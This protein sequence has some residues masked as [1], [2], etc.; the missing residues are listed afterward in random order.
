MPIDKKRDLAEHYEKQFERIVERLNPAQRQ[1]VDTIEGPVL[2]LAGPGTGKTH[3][4]SARIGRI[5]IDTDTAPYNILCLTFT[6]AGV[7]AMRKRLL[8]FI[9][10]EAHRIHIFTFHSF[11]NKI[12]QENLDYFGLQD[13]MPLSDIERV[14]ILQEML[15]TLPYSNPL[16]KGKS[17]PYYYIPHLEHLFRQIKMEGW[18]P[19]EIEKKIR[20]YLESLPARKEYQYQQ[21]RGGFRKGELKKGAFR[22]EQQRMERLSAAAALF[23]EYVRLLGKR[24]RYDYEDMILWVLQAFDRHSFLLSRYQEQYLYILV[25]EYQDTNGSQNEVLQKLIGYWEQPNIFIV[26]DDDQSVYEFQGARLHHLQSFYEKYREDLRLI[27]LEENYR[28][29]QEILRYAGNLVRKNKQRVS[30]ILSG[31]DK[32]LQ[33][34]RPDEGRVSIRVFPERTHE[35]GAILR[36]VEA[37]LSGGAEPGSIAILY[38]RHKQADSLIEL[39]KKRQ[40]PYQTRR[41]INILETPAVRQLIRLLGYFA[42]EWKKPFGGEAQLV[43]FLHYPFFRL[44]PRDIAR[45]SLLAR[46]EEGRNWREMLTDEYF[47]DKSGLQDKESFVQIGRFIEDY[48]GWGARQPLPR[49]VERVINRSGLLVYLLEK[50]ER[51][52]AI[53]LLHAFFRFVGQEADKNPELDLWGLLELMDRMIRNRIPITI[54]PV[55][56]SEEGVLFSTAHSA[57]GLEFDYV[58]LVDCVSESWEPSGRSAW[59]AFPLPDTLTFSGEE[60]PLE[61]RR[62]LFYVAM[63]RARTHLF[64]SYSEKREDG[65]QLE[66]ARF[67]DEM[68]QNTGVEI[69]SE[70]LAEEEL[71]QTIGLH[72]REIPGPRVA[73]ERELRDEL[74][75]DFRFSITSLN[76]YLRCPLS[77]YYE[78]LLK[79]PS[80]PSEAGLYGIAM[81]YALYIF[82][83]RMRRDKQKEFPAQEALLKAFHEEMNRRKAHF[84]QTGFEHRLERG[85]KNL[86]SFYQENIQSWHKEVWVEYRMRQL[87]VDG[88]PVEGTID[89][90]ELFPAGEATLVDYKTGA[91]R[92]EKLARPTESEPLGGSY[93][94]QLLFYKLLFDQMRSHDYL[95]RSGRIVYLD[96]DSKGTFRTT[97]YELSLED[98]RWMRELLRKTWEAV[99]TADSFAGCNEPHCKWCNLFRERSVDF[100]LSDP[101]E[102]ELDDR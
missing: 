71:R 89:K 30:N 36:Q 26:G 34:N 1:A 94:R 3:V 16:K 32:V 42:E 99:Q 55:S 31:Q 73:L 80:F 10:P 19:E 64:L 93:W 81:H 21:N 20:N 91:F 9:G 86:A 82:F 47:L 50:P 77:F 98:A 12:I 33:A 85:K 101:G 83:A 39:F 56:G 49:L 100:S 2:V 14:E 25:D 40:L 51:G 18:K 76:T 70:Q 54:Q 60:D 75:E 38:A 79:A 37:L 5:L 48:L 8:E 102:E 53:Q 15:D 90:V 46:E 72:L 29:T 57:K 7:H 96:P 28:S 69:E 74:L 52:A 88:V 95:A 61:A 66:R 35:E 44:L 67:I 13:L 92:R 6:D 63:T 84:S 27:M 58:F 17:N 87:E 11:C 59:N 4:L 45:L 62:R 41:N 22:I 24:N 97:T 23:P 43:E 68:I 78:H 65:K